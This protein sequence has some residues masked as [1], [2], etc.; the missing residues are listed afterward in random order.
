MPCLAGVLIAAFAVMF[1]GQSGTAI[2]ISDTGTLAVFG[3][4]IVYAVTR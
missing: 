2:V 1:L 4:H 3:A